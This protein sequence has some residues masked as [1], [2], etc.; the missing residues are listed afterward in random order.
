MDKDK[1][2]TPKSIEDLYLADFKRR[3]PGC[4]YSVEENSFIIEQPWGERNARLVYGI[5]ELDRICELNNIILP[6]KYDVIIHIDMNMAE[7]LW[8]FLS[9]DEDVLK[10]YLNRKFDYYFEGIKY[11]CFFRQPTERM[12]SIARAFKRLPSK[13]RISEPIVPQIEAFRDSQVLEE[14]TKRAQ[15]FFSGKIPR[16]FFIQTNKNNPLHKIDLNRFSKH[17]N[18]IM[19]YY[20]RLTPEIIIRET[21]DI[22]IKKHKPLRY[23]EEVFPTTI[24]VEG[25]DDFMLQL[26]SVGYG[27]S[28]RFAF[29]Y[30]Y[31]VIEYAGF[32]FLDRKAKREL[33]QLIREPSIISCSEDKVNQLFAFLAD[34]SHSDDVKMKRVIEEYCNPK[35]IWKE[36]ENDREFFSSPLSFD[37]GFE[38]GPLI[39][40]D[41]TEETWDT[42]RMPNLYD[43]L[44]R[45]RNSLVHAREKRQSS[46]ILPTKANN[47]KIKRYLPIISR[48][49]EQI[50]LNKE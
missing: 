2:A 47:K 1:P 22:D 25:L 39:S 15:E 21:E 8:G 5:T 10:C 43:H 37:G 14:L 12:M 20:D 40:K 42:M 36:I 29:V 33:R 7:F 27:T 17:L 48:L 32:Y 30:F 34:L 3:N 23:I 19:N 26:I 45:I 6:P 38:L 49:A 9:P 50:T 11:E 41:T 16:N 24:S 13:V 4:I 35:I 28:A 31:Q 44:T 46:L 18:F